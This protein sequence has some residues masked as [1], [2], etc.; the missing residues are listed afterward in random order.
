MNRLMCLLFILCVI[1][2][3]S[4]SVL[5]WGYMT[6]TYFANACGQKSG[7]VNS[8]EIYGSV[9]NDAYNFVFDA[10]G[11]YM[12]DQTHQNYMPVVDL[13]W[14]ADLKNVAYGFK[15]HNELSGIDYTAHLNAF[16]LGDVGYAVYWG[17]VLAPSIVP[18]IKQIFLNA[19]LDEPT[20]TYIA[21]IAAPSLGHNLIEDAVDLLVKYNLDSKIGHKLKQ[22]AKTRPKE[23]PLLLSAAYAEGLANFAQISL[24]EAQQFIIENEITHQHQMV[25]WGG[26]YCLKK[27]RDIQALAMINAQIGEAYLEAAS[28]V[29]VTITPDLVI[30]FLMM[31]MATAEPTYQSEIAQTLAYLQGEFPPAAAP[32]AKSSESMSSF[33]LTP[34]GFTLGANYP[35]PF[36]PTTT[37]SYSLPAESPVTIMIYNSLGQEVATLVNEQQPAGQYQATWNAAGLPSGVYF[38]QIKANGF[39]STRRMH[40]QK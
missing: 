3:M 27:G 11:Q 34:E 5:G 38:C 18:E 35:N 30:T 7:Q 32:L 23:T 13:A 40:L 36:N 24:E 2:L 31:A 17:Q 29:D 14:S 16:T 6:H 19:G 28:G 22:A 1:V 8:Q 25:H 21:T 33:S 39:V 12:H 37:I 26:I 10:K 15:L 9:L 4:S 20:A